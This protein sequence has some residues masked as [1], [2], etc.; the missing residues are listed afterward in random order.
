MHKIRSDENMSNCYS[1][2]KKVMIYYNL[3]LINIHRYETIYL[4]H[5]AKKFDIRVVK[6]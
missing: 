3:I 6:T 2:G 5:Y 4:K 1:L